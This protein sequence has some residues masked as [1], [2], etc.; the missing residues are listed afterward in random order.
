MIITESN[1]GRRFWGGGCRG[2]GAVVDRVV[3]QEGML[4][5]G[6]VMKRV[7]GAVRDRRGENLEASR[8][9]EINKKPA[10]FVLL[11]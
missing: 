7:K 1:A 5:E 2:T 3:G 9:I 4:G 8:D 11:L 6:N 10:N